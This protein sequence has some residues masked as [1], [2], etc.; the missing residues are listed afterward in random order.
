MHLCCDEQSSRGRC[1]IQRPLSAWAAALIM[2]VLAEP[3]AFAQGS[4]TPITID[5]LKGVVIQLS[6]TMSQTVNRR[7]ETYNSVIHFNDTIEIAGDG[8]LTFRSEASTPSR[9]DGSMRRGPVAVAGPTVIGTP[10]TT[11]MGRGPG[12]A[13]WILEDTGNLVGLRTYKGGGLKRTVSFNRTPEGLKCAHLMGWATES[14]KK[15]IEVNSAVDG[16]PML[17]LAW[18][19]LSFRC[20]MSQRSH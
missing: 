20:S 16:E 4:A 9:K 10:T 5:D 18:Q 12:Y 8:R 6:I 19:Q 7:G 13:V 3:A 11:N 14:G 2:V 15:G 17:I 1:G